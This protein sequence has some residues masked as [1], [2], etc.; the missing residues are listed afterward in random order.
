MDTQT[1]QL[2]DNKIYCELSLNLFEQIYAL[3]EKLGFDQD[4]NNYIAY[5]GTTGRRILIQKKKTTTPR[6]A[7]K[8]SP[9]RP[10]TSIAKRPIKIP[11]KRI[12]NVDDLLSLNQE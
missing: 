5:D 2:K 9:A 8:K 4:A 3:V 12:L 1:L 6:A 11:P 7:P 10:A